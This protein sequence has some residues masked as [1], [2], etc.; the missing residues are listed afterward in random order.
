[1]QRLI[2]NSKKDFAMNQLN[3][4]IVLLLLFMLSG[5]SPAFATPVNQSSVKETATQASPLP[6]E[7]RPL[8]S[9][10]LT[11]SLQGTATADF[12]N[13]PIDLTPTAFESLTVNGFLV[14][15]NSK[16]D[17]NLLY[18]MESWKTVDIVD[19]NNEK[20]YIDFVSPNKKFILVGACPDR[21]N[22]SLQAGNKII[23]ANLPTEDDWVLAGWLDNERAVFLSQMKPGQPAQPQNQMIYNVF[24][25]EKISLQ[26]YLPDPQTV[27][28]PGRFTDKL[29]VASVSP[30]LNRVLFSDQNNSLVLWN[31]DTQKEVVSLPFARFE[32][33]FREDGWSPDG[34]KF[35]TISPDKFFN[36]N[37]LPPARAANELFMFDMDGN[38]TQLTHYNQK[39]PFASIFNF[40]WSPDN[41]HLAFWLTTGDDVSGYK[42]LQQWLAVFD[43]STL[44]TKVYR[45]ASRT[46]SSSI[47]WSPDGQQLVVSDWEANLMLVDLAHKTKSP[48]SDTQD[49]RI[50]D[51][52]AP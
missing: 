13:N 26:L 16:T 33:P 29:F 12:I 34:K 47:I 48:I 46:I 44:E 37:R 32:G 2:T 43:T 51:W 19:K 22:Y 42:N 50:W 39:L 7:T 41:R 35:V 5:C 30:S 24:T 8:V 25:G 6:A 11:D 36:D 3:F 45:S 28:L 40:R 14:L 15:E 17:D 38:L 52:M 10:T 27:D 49:M 9:V 31:L 18:N 4:A 20:M 21:C 23:K 1:L